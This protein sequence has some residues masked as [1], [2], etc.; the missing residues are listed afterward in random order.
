MKITKVKCRSGLTG[1]QA[2]LRDNYANDYA[3]FEGCA[4]TWGIHTRLGYKTP[5]KAWQMN[6]IIQGS[7]DPSDLCKIIGGRRIFAK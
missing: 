5:Q 2:R 3:G 6:P 4:E 1:W 7:V